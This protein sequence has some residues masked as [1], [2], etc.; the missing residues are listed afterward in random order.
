MM[1]MLG[2]RGFKSHPKYCQSNNSPQITHIQSFVG[3]SASSPN[4]PSITDRLTGA[5]KT[6]TPILTDFCDRLHSITLQR[7]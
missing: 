7:I 5:N 1:Y 4:K 3:E 6:A 2:S